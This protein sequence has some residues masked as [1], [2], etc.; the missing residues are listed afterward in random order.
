MQFIQASFNHRPP[1]MSEL[2]VCTAAGQMLVSVRLSEDGS[3]AERAARCCACSCAAPQAEDV[4]STASAAM[5][6]KA[7]DTAKPSLA[8]EAAISKAS[9]A[10][11][12]AD[13]SI[14]PVLCN[15]SLQMSLAAV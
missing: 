1:V 9:E 14:L 7:V 2:V 11:P 13:F 8:M 15:P 12:A 5:A 10:G 4:L 6:R 3:R